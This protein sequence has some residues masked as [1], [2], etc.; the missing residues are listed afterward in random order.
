MPGKNWWLSG[1]V[2]GLGAAR[3]DDQ[4]GQGGFG[5]GDG[6]RCLGLV[7]VFGCRSEGFRIERLRVHAVDL[8]EAQD[9]DASGREAPGEI[10]E[11][12]VPGTVREGLVTII[13]AGPG[14]QHDGRMRARGRRHG[15]GAGDGERAGPERHLLFGEGGGIGVIGALPLVCHEMRYV[16]VALVR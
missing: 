6:D 12:L 11:G 15:Q 4:A 10:L 2:R 16:S 14:Q 1:S 5:F 13:G 3:H 7:R 9:H 8:V